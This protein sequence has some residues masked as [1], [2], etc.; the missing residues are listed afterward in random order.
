MLG[1]SSGQY[2]QNWELHRYLHPV[3]PK[4]HKAFDENGNVV[5]EAYNKRIVK[6]LEEF[7]WYIEA[8]KNQRSEDTPYNN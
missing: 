6:F 5:D 7:E 3:V 1:S 4:V 8:L 2:L